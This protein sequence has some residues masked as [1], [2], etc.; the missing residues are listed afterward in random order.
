MN[1]IRVKIIK[2]FNEL[3]NYTRTTIQHLNYSI[4]VKNYR[5]NKFITGG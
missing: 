5:K 2:L 1:L 4:N 3:F